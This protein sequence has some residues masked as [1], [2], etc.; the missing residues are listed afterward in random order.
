MT[1]G[2]CHL[3]PICGS[4]LSEGWLLDT[5]VLISWDVVL[6]SCFL[7]MRF[8][9]LWVRGHKVGGNTGSAVHGTLI[10]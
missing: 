3:T 5:A 7:G 2:E 9:K 8:C 6:G 10:E 4:A 1:A